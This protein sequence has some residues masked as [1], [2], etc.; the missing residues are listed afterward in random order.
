M[1]AC[2]HPALGAHDDT[3]TRERGRPVRD[4]PQPVRLL[5]LDHRPPV[6]ARTT[7]STARPRCR[8]TCS[9]RRRLPSYSFITPNLCNDGHDEPCV[10][11]RPGRAGERQRVPAGLDAADHSARP[12]Y[13]DGGLLIV[14]FDEAEAHR[15]TA[16][17]A[18]AATS[19]SGP[20][21]PNNGG[22][23]RATAAAASGRCCCRRTSSPARSRRRRTTTTRCCGAPRTCS[24]LDHLAYAARDGLKPFGDDVFTRPGGRA[25]GCVGR[26]RSG[27]RRAR[28][29]ACTQRVQGVACGSRPRHCGASAHG[30][31]GTRAARSA[32]S[33]VAT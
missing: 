26:R 11:G 25:R 3:Q 22:P 10:D 4:A 9:R 24:A 28:S 31:T 5:P 27:S 33:P 18:P 2:R 13:K 7:S 12:A 1:P 21:T 29:T 8:A 6:A 23:T 32:S 14:T 17:R 20:N 30:S 16:T 19:R 15:T